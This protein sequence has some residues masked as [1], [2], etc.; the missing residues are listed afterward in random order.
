MFTLLC[1]QTYEQIQTSLTSDNVPEIK[2]FTIITY[3]MLPANLPFQVDKSLKVQFNWNGICW[4]RLCEK[5]SLKYEATVDC[6]YN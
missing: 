5:H 1:I 2:I 4:T 3:N 6:F